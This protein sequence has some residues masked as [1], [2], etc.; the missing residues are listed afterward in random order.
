ML[1][2]LMDHVQSF[3][4]DHTAD[5]LARHAARPQLK[6][7]THCANMDC[8]EPIG[9]ARTAL[10]AQLCLICQKAEEARGAHLQVWRQR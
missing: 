6:G 10:G 5:A 7:R 3:N 9:D 1:P 8:G 2:D 4:D